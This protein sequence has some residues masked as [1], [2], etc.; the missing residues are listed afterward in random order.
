MKI[1]KISGLRPDK[2]TNWTDEQA[3]RERMT[4]IAA[5]KFAE[6]YTEVFFQKLSHFCDS[7]YFFKT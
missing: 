7:W 3:M 6:G 4:K 1:R 2:P 5:K